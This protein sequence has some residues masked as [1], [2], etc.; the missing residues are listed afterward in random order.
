MA[1]FDCNKIRLAK[2]STGEQVKTLQTQLRNLGY[3]ATYKQG[4][5]TKWYQID[6]NFGYWTEQ[7]VIAFQNAYNLA[8]D[9]VFGPVT[10]KKLTQVV[11]SKNT[12]NATQTTTEAQTGTVS[13]TT[14][15]DVEI[16]SFDCPKT[17]LKIYA[18][19]DEVKKLQTMLKTLG[20]YDSKIDGDFGPLTDKAVRDFQRKTR[21]DDDGWF[22]PK[23]CPDLNYA[24]Q[25]KIG[26]IKET[27]SATTA[28]TS[29]GYETPDYL[30]NV[31]I[32]LTVL[33]EVIVLPDST[34]NPNTAAKVVSMGGIET[35]GN[36]NCETVSLME[37]SSGDDVT[38]LQTILKARGYYTRQ[39]DGDFGPWTKKAVKKLQEVQG[40]DPDGWFGP[41]TCRKLQGT[42]ATSSTA[43]GTADKKNKEY[44]IK[45]FTTFSS[46]D[47]AEGLSHEVSL[48]TPYSVEKLNHIR[49]YQ[50]TIVDIFFGDDRIYR[51]D[52]YI[53]DIKVTHQND[54]WGISIA[55]VGYTAFLDVQIEYERTAKQSEILKELIEKAGLKAN[56]DITGLPDEEITI[57]A[58]ADTGSAGSG[59]GG[60]T[61]VHG[62][63]CTPTAS[64]SAASFDIDTCYGNTKIGDSNANYARDTANMTAKEA[65]LDVFNRFHYGPSLSSSE[66]Y[67][68]NRRCPQAMWTKTGK[69]WGNCADIARLVKAMG[70]VHGLK[71]GIRHCPGH[72]YNLIEIDGKV[73]RFDCCF[74][75][76]GWTSRGF[77]NEKCNDLNRNGGPWS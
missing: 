62:N 39:I 18:K 1:I 6:G 74:T 4:G 71:V 44:V 66:V 20:Y 46:N 2:N 61:E 52:G 13:T 23:T 12:Q 31:D 28:Q 38:K 68:N 56:I 60:L 57:K 59:G 17:S 48:E 26:V 77:G 64:I 76:T 53:S 29:K 55:L 33:P 21:H 3:Y 5:V 42:N 16:L 22:G 50:K 36:F 7:A 54:G 25:Q 8:T 43:T 10:C 75:S 14:T 35:E 69:F 41:K 70:E 63:D 11:E 73:Y 40:N 30:K 27:T 15:T 9:G 49:R 19:G 37:G 45:D 47:D 72:Y 58:V 65:I 67:W 24:Y 32:K 51:H 34:I